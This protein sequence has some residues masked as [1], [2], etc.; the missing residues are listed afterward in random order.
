MEKRV[1]YE[2]PG[3]EDIEKRNVAY[4][5]NVPLTMDIYYPHQLLP[6]SQLPAVIFVLGYPNSV[7]HERFGI[8]LKDAG[9]Y[10]SWGQ[11]AAASGLIA[12]TYETT[13]P[14]RDIYSILMYVR[15]N[16]KALRID[17]DRIGAWACSGNVP[18]ALRA[19]VDASTN[20]RCAVLY[21]G[22][23]LDR[24]GSNEMEALAERNGCAY[25]CTGRSVDDLSREIPLFIVRSG[26]DH[27]QLNGSIEHF[28]C[29]ATKRNIP[30]TFVNYAGGHHGF[31]LDD[32]AAPS[33]EIIKHTLAFLRENLSTPV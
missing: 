16:A 31:D 4:D 30:L 14:E 24:R 2:I 33:R 28:V 17:S 9:Q 8:K 27:P 32:D 26:E 1:V 21:Y 20:L 18:V 13:Q 22:M 11:L 19:L 12:I 15:E 7:V 10:V 25:P 23:M 3:M 29:E 6:G 5:N